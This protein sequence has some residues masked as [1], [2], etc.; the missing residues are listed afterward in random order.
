MSYGLRYS[1]TAWM[2]ALLVL[3][4]VIFSIL[5]DDFLKLNLQVAF[6]FVQVNE[7]VWRGAVWMLITSMFLHAN[8]MHLLG[9][10]VFL[11]IFGLALEEQVSR[12]LWFLT[13]MLSGLVGNMMFLFLGGNSV[14]LGASGA[15]WGLL[16]MGAGL[17]GVMGMIFFAGFNIFA[18]GGFLAHAG[19]LIAGLLLRYQLRT[20]PH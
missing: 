5:S 12:K 4:Y 8:I 10:L 19:G 1:P 15:I 2:I 3:I 17:S 13:Y 6:P 14:G 11:F 18:G 20:H 16:G 7:L 9:N